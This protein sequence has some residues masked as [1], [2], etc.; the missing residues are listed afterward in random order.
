MK[1]GN[2]NFLEPSGPLQACNGTAL[3][4]P[5]RKYCILFRQN[6]CFIRLRQQQFLIFWQLYEFVDLSYVTPAHSR[7]RTDYTGQVCITAEALRYKEILKDKSFLV[8]RKIFRKRWGLESYAR[9][10]LSV[11]ACWRWKGWFAFGRS[12]AEERTVRLHREYGW[13]EQTADEDKRHPSAPCR[14]SRSCL[15][16]QRYTIFWIT[17]LAW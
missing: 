9:H 13:T 5:L 3:P 8:T 11:G 7:T 1:S 2:L 12:C 14:E 4:L 15:P 16:T 10:I 6:W 17:K